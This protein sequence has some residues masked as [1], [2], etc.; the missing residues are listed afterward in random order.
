MEFHAV[1]ARSFG[2]GERG[3]VADHRSLTT[4]FPHR[5]RAQVAD[6]GGRT[7]AGNRTQIGGRSRLPRQGSD[8]VGAVEGRRHPG[9]G[10]HRH[11]KRNDLLFDRRRPRPESR[12]PKA[13]SLSILF[14]TGRKGPYRIWCG[15]FCMEVE[16]NAGHTI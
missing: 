9:Q 3:L 5:L 6:T 14:E 15:P 13:R 12:T 8:P 1:K 16:V 7:D 4:A 10:G 11:D 2:G